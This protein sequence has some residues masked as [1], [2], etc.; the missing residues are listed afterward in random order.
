MIYP[1]V[2]SLVTEQAEVGFD[3][4]VLALDLSVTL[5]VVC[6]G[7]PVRYAKSFVQRLHEPRG[8]LRSAVRYNLTRY[9]MKTED[10]AIVQICDALC[11]Y[12]GSAGDEMA[13]IGIVINV[14][15]YRVKPAA[16]RELGDEIDTNKLPGTVRYGLGV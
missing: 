10:L 2:L 16:L 14:N 4:L 15:S 13:L 8:E 6:G 11:G 9:S 3:F 5:R 7:E 12:L 1:V